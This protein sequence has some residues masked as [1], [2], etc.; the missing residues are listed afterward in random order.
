[1]AT[2]TS[3]G[4]ASCCAA[5]KYF[6]TSIVRMYVCGPIQCSFCLFEGYFFSC[7]YG[8]RSPAM[9]QPPKTRTTLHPSQSVQRFHLQRRAARTAPKEAAGTS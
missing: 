8:Q 5:A 1:M 7:K 4:F 3:P 2:R 9:G 6:L